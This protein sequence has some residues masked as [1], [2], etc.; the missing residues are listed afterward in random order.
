MSIRYTE[1][2]IQYIEGP[3]CV[4]I[5]EAFQ[6]RD[7]DMLL[8]EEPRQETYSLAW[9]VGVTVASYGSGMPKTRFTG[10]GRS[11]KLAK[12]RAAQAAI[13]EL[14]KSFGETRVNLSGTRHANTT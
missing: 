1:G 6:A 3:P 5:H 9:E 10:K 7:I 12:S 4:V 8:W 14:Q 2:T 11:K 13:D